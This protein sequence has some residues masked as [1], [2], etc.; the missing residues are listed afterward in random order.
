[1]LFDIQSFNFTYKLLYKD[2]LLKK[3]KKKKK[4]QI[5][6]IL[7]NL[8]PKELMKWFSQSRRRSRM[9]VRMVI[10]RLQVQSPP[11]RQ[12]FFVEIGHEIFSMVILFL[13]LIQERQFVSFWQK[14]VHKYSFYSLED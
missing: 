13:P 6:N 2:S 3:K 9:L 12:H 5:T 4:K 14:N 10:K 11:G 7:W 1:M 8:A